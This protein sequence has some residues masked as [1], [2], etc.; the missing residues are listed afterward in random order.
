MTTSFRLATIDDAQPILEFLKRHWGE[1]HIFVTHPEVFFWQYKSHDSKLNFMLA[2]ND[3]SD[4]IIALIGFIP[5]SHFDPE[6]RHEKDVWGAVWKSAEGKGMVGLQLLLSMQK[7]L[8]VASYSGIGLSEG[9]Q[10]IYT[11]LKYEVGTMEHYYITTEGNTQVM[12]SPPCSATP[13]RFYPSSTLRELDSSEVQSIDLVSRCSPKKSATYLVNRYANHPYYDYLFHSVEMEGKIVAIVVSR[14]VHVVDLDTSCLRIVDWYGDWSAPL[15]H[16]DALRELICE[17]KCEYVD[18]VC[19]VENTGHFQRHGFTLKDPAIEIVPNYFEPFVKDN[20]DLKYVYT[21]TH[22]RFAFF[23]GDS[24][25]DRP[26][27]LKG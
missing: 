12:M 1:H 9:A 11:H 13:K 18:L 19:K 8:S 2:V 25:Q 3:D 22:N 16:R 26:N 20:I 21:G 27:I 24:D 4:S 5:T 10:Q 7:E 23:K 14:I 6:L 17:L 15:D